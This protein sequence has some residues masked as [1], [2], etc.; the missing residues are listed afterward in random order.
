MTKSAVAK[1]AARTWERIFSDAKEV[2]DKPAAAL[3]AAWARRELKYKTCKPLLY[4]IKKQV[5]DGRSEGTKSPS[6]RR[7]R[8]RNLESWARGFP[9]STRIEF[10][11]CNG[12]R[13]YLIMN[14]LALGP[15]VSKCTKVTQL[16]GEL[17]YDC[18]SF[19]VLFVFLLWFTRG[20]LLL[21]SRLDCRKHAPRRIFRKLRPLMMI[22]LLLLGT[23]IGCPSFTFSHNIDNK[24]N[25]NF[26]SF[27]KKS[28]LIKLV[29][30]SKE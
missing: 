12:T 16:V 19:F 7:L 26:L 14:R 23:V 3:E 4:V 18:T 15:M 2:K 30:F 10:S 29:A 27:Q 22:G 13:P 1:E 20:G 9:T 6:F 24:F 11:W 8:W 17:N 25:S 5:I 21:C 28:F